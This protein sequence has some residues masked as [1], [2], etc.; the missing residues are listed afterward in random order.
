[1]NKNCKERIKIEEKGGLKLKDILGSKNPF[2]KSKCIQQTCPL[3]TES[4]YVDVG[5][6]DLMQH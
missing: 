6:E 2:P 5:T 3:C 1:V 4:Q